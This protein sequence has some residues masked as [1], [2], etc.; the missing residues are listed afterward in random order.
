MCTIRLYLLHKLSWR[1]P[2][3]LVH[4]RLESRRDVPL[5]KHKYLKQNTPR[6]PPR[7]PDCTLVTQLC[8]RKPVIN[9]YKGGMRIGGMG[10]QTQT[11]VPPQ[12][13]AKQ[14]VKLVLPTELVSRL[15]EMSRQTQMPMSLLVA[16]ILSSAIAPGITIPRY[17][18][19]R[20]PRSKNITV[21]KTAA[22]GGGV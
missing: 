14:K 8:K 1:N 22:Q 3:Y 15:R 17:T 5:E 9:T 11:Q 4:H 12:R 16:L 21:E 19:P 7:T 18:K 6:V 13:G 20:I 2:K 10:A